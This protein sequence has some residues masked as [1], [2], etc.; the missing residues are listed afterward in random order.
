M[1]VSPR[2][3][4]FPVLTSKA[5]PSV[6]PEVSRREDL[7]RDLWN[8]PEIRIPTDWTHVVRTVQIW[9]LIQW[10][11]LNVITVSVIMWSNWPKESKSQISLNT[12]LWIRKIFGF[13]IIW[14]MWSVMIRPKLITLISGIHSSYFILSGS[15][16]QNLGLHN[17][18]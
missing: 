10:A 15:I 6:E 16:F 11:P 12:I 13:V 5:D 18:Y 7:D 3:D 2:P 9:W 14:L 8:Q 17:I 1:F 4:P